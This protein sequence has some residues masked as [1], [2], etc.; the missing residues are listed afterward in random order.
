MDTTNQPM[1]AP[2]PEAAPRRSEGGLRIVKGRTMRDALL[3]ARKDLG[4]RA[5]VVDQR[6]EPGGVTLVVSDT[7]PRSTQM[8][9]AMRETAARLLEPK[10]E[11]VAEAPA[12]PA[13]RRTPLADVER[14]LREH[15]GSRELR[16]RVLEGVVQLESA[17]AHPLDLAAEVVGRQ[18]SVASLPAVAGRTAVVALLGQT[19]AGK[20]T[21]VAKLA[22]RMVRAGRRVVLATLDGGRIGAGEQL[23]AFGAELRVPVITLD[24]PAR[25]AAELARVPGRVDVL[26]VDGSGDEA[27]DIAVLADFEAQCGAAGAPVQVASLLVLPATASADSIR[28]AIDGA[29]AIEPVGAVVTKVDEADRPLPALE[30]AHEA[31]LGLA[32]LTNGPDLAPHFHRASPERFA[33]VALLGRIA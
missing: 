20:T 7:V 4:N 14:R 1:T 32:F 2:T 31:G 33:D 27:R 12:A 10:P 25:L 5:V 16:E 17:D 9:S 26:L 8:L 30:Q 3:A 28:A 13:R 22:S 18:F 15:G 6:T 29:E 21:T 19:G 11:P 24:Q 23:K